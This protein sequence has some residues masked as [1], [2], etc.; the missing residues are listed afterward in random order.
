[1]DVPGQSALYDPQQDRQTANQQL[2]L[3]GGQQEQPSPAFL[4]AGQ[5]EQQ[6]QPPE[7]PPGEFRSP[8]GNL[9]AEAL[10][11]LGFSRAPRPTSSRS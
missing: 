8:R 11:G 1:M 9:R 7:Q 3:T 2:V 10:P 5:S 4:P 6:Q